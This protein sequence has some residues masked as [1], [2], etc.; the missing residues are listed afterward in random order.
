MLL[1]YA[2]YQEA[3][4]KYTNLPK[5]LDVCVYVTHVCHDIIFLM[6]RNLGDVLRK[7]L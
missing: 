5:Y 4:G 2:T 6:E 3:C 1:S 7:A